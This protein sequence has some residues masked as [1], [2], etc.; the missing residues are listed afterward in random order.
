MNKILQICA[1]GIFLLISQ[2]LFAQPPAPELS[3]SFFN[4]TGSDIKFNP[5]ISGHVDFVNGKQNTV[6]SNGRASANVRVYKVTRESVIY[7][8][9][10]DQPIARMVLTPVINTKKVAIC[11][12]PVITKDPI[13]KIERPYKYQLKFEFALE[14]QPA[15]GNNSS[16][17]CGDWNGV[18]RESLHIGIYADH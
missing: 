18:E 7:L 1:A 3:I 5:I 10:N 6:A 9:Q 4:S 11:L 8:T 12:D 15:Y 17:E 2:S 14:N 16:G 13:T